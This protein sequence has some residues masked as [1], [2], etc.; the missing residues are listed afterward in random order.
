MLSAELAVLPSS[1][2]IHLSA[3]STRSVADIEHRRPR[4]SLRRD[5]PAALGVRGRPA[6]RRL[7]LGYGAIGEEKIDEGVRRLRSV[8]ARH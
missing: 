8:F 4:A 3:T 1:V 2:G 5:V 7:V 6:A